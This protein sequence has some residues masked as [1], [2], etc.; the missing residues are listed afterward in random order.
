[1]L[2][3][4]F[5]CGMIPPMKMYSTEQIISKLRQEVHH[6]RGQNALARQLKVNPRYISA[7]LLNGYLHP[8]VAAVLGFEP[9]RQMYR[10]KVA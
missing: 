5:F 2:T 6:A 1:M 10:R 7:A 9:I 3:V 4:F 8:T